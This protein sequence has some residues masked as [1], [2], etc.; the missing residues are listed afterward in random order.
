MPAAGGRR[1]PGWRR[2]RRPAQPAH[3][4]APMSRPYACRVLCILML[5]ETRKAGWR[6][7]WR[8][9]GCWPGRRCRTA[10]AAHPGRVQL[11]CA[12]SHRHRSALAPR[13]TPTTRSTHARPPQAQAALSITKTAP[14]P[15]ARPGETARYG[16]LV[17]NTG[18]AAAANVRL[19]DTLPGTAAG[20]AWVVEAPAGGC[21]I[22]AG[23]LACTLGSLA[24]DASATV[25]ISARVTD[26]AVRAGGRLTNRATVVADGVQAVTSAAASITVLV[27]QAVALHMLPCRASRLPC[28][29]RGARHPLLACARQAACCHACRAAAPPTPRSIQAQAP[30]VLPTL[31]LSETADATTVSTGERVGFAL[32]LTKLAG[33]VVLGG[34]PAALG[35]SCHPT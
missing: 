32:T 34:P 17:R 24:A 26:A 31:T 18:A 3:P 11:P 10:A 14:T 27:S 21:A 20:M 29:Q 9:G 5:N 30:L 28:C 8:A 15:I 33:A 7:R 16:M 6:G 22:S 1:L 13:S 19:S 35:C 2:G 23:K 12:A 25:T 4:C